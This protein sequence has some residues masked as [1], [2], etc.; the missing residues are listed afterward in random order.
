M[1]EKKGTSYEKHIQVV[2]ISD[3]SPKETISLLENYE[4]SSDKRNDL[5]KNQLHTKS[6]RY[7]IEKLSSRHNWKDTIKSQCKQ[8]IYTRDGL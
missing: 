3:C 5:F 2:S 6:I 1:I 8:E 7:Y 4:K